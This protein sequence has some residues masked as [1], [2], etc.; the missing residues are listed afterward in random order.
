MI[1]VLK[2]DIRQE[3]MNNLITW[4]ESQNVRTHISNGEYKT[5]V[6]LRGQYFGAGYRPYKRVG[7]C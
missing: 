1:L 2:K 4:L 6:G 3:E 5:V 7:H